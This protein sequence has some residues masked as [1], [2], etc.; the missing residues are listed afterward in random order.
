MIPF[1]AA[2]LISEVVPSYALCSAWSKQ[3]VLFLF[4]WQHFMSE[5]Q[6]HPNPKD[7]SPL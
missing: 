1:E 5:D 2:T 6:M 3:M 7:E 4:P